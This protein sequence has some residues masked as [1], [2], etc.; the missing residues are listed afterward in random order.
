MNK[1]NQYEIEVTIKPNNKILLAVFKNGYCVNEMLLNE[2][3]NSV[4][5]IISTF[6]MISEDKS[7]C[8]IKYSDDNKNRYKK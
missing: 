5:R 8:K 7:N 1:K 2:K 6:K 3:D 4:K